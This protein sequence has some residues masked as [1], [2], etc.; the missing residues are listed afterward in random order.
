MTDSGRAPGALHRRRGR[1]PR[2]ARPPHRRCG[3]TC[4][5]RAPSACASTSSPSSR[6][7]STGCAGPRHLANAALTAGLELRC[8][9][10]R[11]TTPLAHGQVND[12]PYGGG[13]GMVIRVDVIAAVPRG[14]LRGAGARRC[15]SGRR[16]IVLTP[17][18]RPFTD[19]VAS[20]ARARSPRSPC[21]AGATR[22]STSA[23]TR[24][25][26]TTRSAWGPSSWPGARW[27]RWP[28]STPSPGA[29][30]AP[31]ATRRAWWP[32]RSREALGGR[33]EHPHYT[34][35]ARLRRPP[36]ARL[37]CSRATTGR[38]RAGAT[39]GS[40]APR[41]LVARPTERFRPRGLPCYAPRRFAGPRPGH[42]ESRST[43][44]ER[45][46]EP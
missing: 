44:R 22:V 38:S 19:A 17:R 7:G 33:I 45:H 5:D 29:S 11:D 37:C 32:S 27:R 15:A 42:A 26:P 46:R 14:R 18:G 21:C 28:S 24:C 16:V 4:S 3:P 10:P 20:R 9:S 43:R 36:G 39:S 2:R 31:S 13:P 30:P 23:C 8:F 34:R 6:S 40:L 35:P 41:T 25:W 1:R 12:S